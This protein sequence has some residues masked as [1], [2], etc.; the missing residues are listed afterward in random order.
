MRQNR[1][2]VPLAFGVLK[3]C[4]EPEPFVIGQFAGFYPVMP[5]KQCVYLSNDAGY[6]RPLYALYKKALACVTIFPVSAISRA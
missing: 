2:I 4:I 5:A 3:L 1:C 6:L